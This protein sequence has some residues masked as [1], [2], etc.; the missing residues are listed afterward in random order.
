MKASFKLFYS[1]K[2]GFF[3]FIGLLIIGLIILLFFDKES[4]HLSFNQ[5]H[6]SFFDTFFK[7][8]TYLGDGIVFP[9][10]IAGLLLIKRRPAPAFIYAGVLT[11]LISYVLKNWVFIGYARPYEVFKDT[12]HLID[13]VK[14]RHWHSFPSGHTT[15]AFALFITAILFSKKTIYN[16][17]GLVWQ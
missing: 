3:S 16:F 2:W 8:A 11:L 13:G 6:N 1:K 5:H 14:M 10:V 17:Y 15:S 4:I 9:I 7:Y 12:I